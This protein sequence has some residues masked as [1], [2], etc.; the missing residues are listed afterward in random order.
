MTRLGPRWVKR[1]HLGLLALVWIWP[2][3]HPGMA[4][5][6]QNKLVLSGLILLGLHINLRHI[7]A[8]RRCEREDPTKETD[9]DRTR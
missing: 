6:V 1:I 3:I 2:L 7:R 9:H 8:M 5:N 4:I